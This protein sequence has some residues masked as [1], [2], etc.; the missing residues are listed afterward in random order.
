MSATEETIFKDIIG[1][2]ISKIFIDS[3]R[4][5]IK[6]IFD[7][8]ETWLMYHSQDCCESVTIES[9]VGDLEDITDSPLLQAVAISYVPEKPDNDSETWTFYRFST[10][11][12]TITIRWFGQSNGYYS[13]SVSFVKE[14]TYVN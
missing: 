9:I 1:K 10:I 2:T 14:D 8:S 4:E 7:N 5:K 3:N 12:G 13:E 11:K 6:F